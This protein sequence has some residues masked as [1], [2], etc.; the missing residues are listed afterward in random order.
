[1]ALPIVQKLRHSPVLEDL[2]ASGIASVPSTSDDAESSCTR[3][4][5]HARACVN[6]AVQTYFESR[7]YR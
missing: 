4:V 5:E 2:D 1:M 7:H 3:Q 6:L